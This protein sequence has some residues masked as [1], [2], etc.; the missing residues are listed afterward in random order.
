MPEIWWSIGFPSSAKCKSVQKPHANLPDTPVALTSASKYF[1]MLPG[2]PGALQNALRLWKSILR[3]YWKH[4]QLWMSIQDATRFE[5]W[6]SQLLERVRA[7]H[8]TVGE[9][10]SSCTWD[11]VLCCQQSSSYSSISIS[12]VVYHIHLCHIHRI[13]YLII[14]HTWGGYQGRVILQLEWIQYY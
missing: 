9:I 8:R 7:P 3:C 2:P 5:D 13:R 1:E 6:D 11:L 4:L 12:H 10:A 14:W